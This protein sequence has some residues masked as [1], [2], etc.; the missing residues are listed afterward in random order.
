MISTKAAFQYP[1]A[2]ET[3]RIWSVKAGPMSHCDRPLRAG[4]YLLQLLIQL[5][6][7]GTSYGFISF[8]ENFLC[9][10]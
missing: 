5:H 8:T 7:A 4:Y 3:V 9:E 10:L 1:Q 2:D 6:A